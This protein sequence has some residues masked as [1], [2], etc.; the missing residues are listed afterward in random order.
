MKTRIL[1]TYM[2][3]YDMKTEQGDRRQG[4]SVQY[5]FYGENGEELE[6]KP[7]TNGEPAGWRTAKDS[8]DINCASKFV[9][10]PGIYDAE[11]KLRVGSDGKPVNRLTDVLYI[12]KP[13]ISMEKLV[14]DSPRTSRPVAAATAEAK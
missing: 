9:F 14:Q 8:I 10:V 2:S 3:S 7:V 13:V 4:C 12:G 6:S 11:F 1:V 5:L